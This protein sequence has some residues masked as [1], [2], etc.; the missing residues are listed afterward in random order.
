MSE[1]ARWRWFAAW[2]AVG[3]LVAFT[4]LGAATI[5]VFVLAFAVLAVVLVLRS[6]RLWPELLG[7]VFGIGVLCLVVGALHRDY[8]PCPD[9][10]LVVPPGETSVSCGGADPVPW[11]IAGTL[12]S[13]AGA[14][15]YLLARRLRP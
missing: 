10:G 2:A 14:A 12:L 4:L 6:G 5:G 8:A 7:A 13:V 3:G 15:A 1:T 11:L 9:G